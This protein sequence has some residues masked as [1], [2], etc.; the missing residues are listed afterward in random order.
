LDQAQGAIRERVAELASLP[1]VP[2]AVR[3]VSQMAASRRTNASDIADVIVRDQALTAHILRLV[4]S[5]VY[6][7]P[8]RIASV[9]HAVVLL[10]FNVIKGIVL[11]TAVFDR[12]GDGM[13][14][15]WEHSLG[16]ALFSRRIA[17]ELKLPD[18][19][20]LL[21]PGLLH[22]LGKLALSHLFSHDYGRIVAA[23][24]ARRCHVAEIE[25]RVLGVSHE[26]VGDW[27][28]EQWHFPQ[29][30]RE[31]LRH[32]HAPDAATGAPDVCAT[33][34]LAD[35]LARTME[36]GYP[37]DLSMPP[38]HHEAI[39]RLGLDQS[40]VDRILEDTELEMAAGAGVFSRGG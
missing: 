9:S 16:T 36:Y 7:F 31:P 25:Q 5:P 8:G 35:I 34:H 3:Q 24:E 18:A 29:R 20:D 27:L 19:E 23:A 21:V 26:A 37:G 2:D 22:D 12:L 33:V 4:N 38:A 40:Q 14:G 1:T 6:G 39:A 28:A 32:H 10:G 11:G 13:Q 30:L 15:L 17:R